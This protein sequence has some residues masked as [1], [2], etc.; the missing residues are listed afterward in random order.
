MSFMWSSNQWVVF[1]FFLKTFRIFGIWSCCNSFFRQ[2]IFYDLM[3]QDLLQFCLSSFQN[4]FSLIYK[5]NPP[6]NF[7]S[8]KISGFC[9]TEKSAPFSLGVNLGPR[10]SNFEGWLGIIYFSPGDC[11]Y[12]FF[13]LF[14]FGR[15]SNKVRPRDNLTWICNWGIFDM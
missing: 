10:L 12:N 2:I 5:F 15:E 4:I 11:E 14:L 1:H 13:G 3:K 8:R 6:K 7:L 9:R